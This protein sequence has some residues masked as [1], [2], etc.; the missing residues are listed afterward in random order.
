VRKRSRIKI[1]LLQAILSCVSAKFQ[2]SYLPTAIRIGVNKNKRNGVKRVKMYK[3]TGLR[4]P[5]PKCYKATTTLRHK[6]PQAHHTKIVYCIVGPTNKNS[7]N[8]KT[9]QYERFK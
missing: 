5:N 8:K 2:N 4:H 6:K 1:F 3:R 7:L 9:D